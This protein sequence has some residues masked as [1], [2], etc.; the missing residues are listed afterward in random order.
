MKLHKAILIGQTET[1][2]SLLS[3]GVITASSILVGDMR[4]TTESVDYYD[5]VSGDF[6][7]I[8]L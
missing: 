5:S 1:S 6:I 8:A 2:Q 3:Q 7:N 4:I